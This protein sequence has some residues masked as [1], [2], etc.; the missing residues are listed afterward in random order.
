MAWQW[1]NLNDNDKVLLVDR[2]MARDRNLFRSPSEIGDP[3]VGMLHNYEF[4]SEVITWQWPG[5]DRVF[6]VPLEL[7]H[8]AKFGGLVRDVIAWCGQKF[9]D[10]HFPENRK[11]S[12][13][14]RGVAEGIGLSWNGGEVRQEIDK[15]LAF[16]RCFTI[17]NYRVIDELTKSGQVKGETRVIF[18]FINMV[19]RATIRDC[20]AIPRNKQ[21]YD[22]ELSKVY[23]KALRQLT[24]A[25]LPVKALEV[26]HC[27]P[28]KIRASI[29]N[30]A[31][32]LAG[33]VPQREVRL[34]LPTCREICNLVEQP[35]K[36]E[37]Q[38][39]QAVE[40]V[41]SSLFPIMISDYSYVNKGYDIQLAGKL[42]NNRD[43]D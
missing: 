20:R 21:W 1:D 15:I 33:R 5:D 2:N 38:T 8:N 14:L 13:H 31:Y 37:Y 6:L 42:P 4:C 25:P 26:A 12:A 32:Y 23:C 11:I 7:F 29:K 28:R 3:Q 41:F 24:P 34:L 19:G 9:R 30:M 10:D 39:R 36:Y 35:A 43:T 27:A 16:A 22:I 17:Q 40:K 18:G